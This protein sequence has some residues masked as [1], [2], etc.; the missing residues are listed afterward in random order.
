MKHFPT[1]KQE[2]IN[3]AKSLLF[4]LFLKASTGQ[5][6]EEI[7]KH[8]KQIKDPKQFARR[9]G[10]F[11]D[12]SVKEVKGFIT[13]H[14]IYY[15]FDR[16]YCSFVSDMISI[17]CD[18]DE[19]VDM[20]QTD[21]HHDFDPVKY[22]SIYEEIKV[23][24]NRLLHDYYCRVLKSGAKDNI[25]FKNE[26]IYGGK[27]VVS[28]DQKLIED[29][30]KDL[31]FYEYCDYVK[32]GVLYKQFFDELER[33][34]DLKKIGIIGNRETPVS[35]Y[36]SVDDHVVNKYVLDPS[37]KLQKD[38]V[39][40]A[41]F[42]DITANTNNILSKLNNMIESNLK[43]SGCTNGI[44]PLDD[45]DEELYNNNYKR[46]IAVAGKLTA[47]I[48]FDFINDRIIL[49]KHSRDLVEKSKKIKLTGI[50][51]VYGYGKVSS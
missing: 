30:Q 18:F 43:I 17:G 36:L 6:A 44:I 25:I 10:A 20:I 27:C 50:I 11:I 29:L 37:D 21:F 46:I 5:T 9:L 12:F 33:V 19:I 8:F 1:P 39:A 51:S 42:K 38:P 24:F 22:K 45:I 47:T 34:N 26:L 49:D 4:P 31:V 40:I 32:N 41:K 15:L 2:D 14:I 3:I 28:T 13:A 23:T 16:N 35:L 7:D 48:T